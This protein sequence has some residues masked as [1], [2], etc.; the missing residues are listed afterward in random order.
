M[1]S[2]LKIKIGAQFASRTIEMLESSAYGVLS[3]SA[4]RILDRLEIELA[5]HGGKDNGKLPVTYDQFQEF[6]ID[7]QA[8]GPALRELQALG[9]IEITEPGR[10]GSAE[11]RTPNLFRITYRPSKGMKTYGSNE[12]RRIQTAEQAK[13][14]AKGAREATGENPKFQSGKTPRLSGGNPHPKPSIHSGETHTTGNGGETPTTLDIS[15][16]RNRDV[17]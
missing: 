9:F 6:G 16:R 13:L 7:R 14:T 5:H 3:L 10:P 11:R 12:W 17:A 8:I 4:R 1:R 15:G 2:E